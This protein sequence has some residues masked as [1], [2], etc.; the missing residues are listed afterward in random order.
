MSRAYRITVA[1]SLSRHVQVDDG[2]C[3]NLELLPILEK[4]AMGALLAA[5]LEQ[6]GFER[7]GDTATRKE[8]DGITVNR[9]ASVVELPDGREKNDQE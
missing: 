8:K 2:V 1:E 9:F 4:R 3:S 5:E 6:K 7:D